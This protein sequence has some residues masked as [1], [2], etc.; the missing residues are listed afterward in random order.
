MKNL[1][2]S[3]VAVAA[4]ASAASAQVITE[5]DFLGAPGNQPSQPAFS[6]AANVTGSAITRGAGLV[7]SAAGSSISAS[8]WEN[9]T[10]GAGATEYF[11]FGFTVAPGFS[12]DLAGLAI[13]TR[14]S[15]T[16]PGTLGLFYNGDGFTTNLFTFNQA[17]GSNFVNSLIDLS[18]LPALSGNVEF[19]I[20][21]IGNNAAA[22]GSTASAGTLRLTS[23]FENGQFNRTM[24]FT[25]EVIPTPGAIALA[26]LAG[27][28]G[29]RRRRN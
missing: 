24:Q 1:S 3:I 25:G 19:R 12:V 14:S 15:N 23:Y 7:A 13:G 2:V 9:A 29:L 18:S 22:G 20:I 10:Q 4:L 17:P 11:S 28:V 26:G 27:V 16:G 8:G 21:E 6:S 5:W